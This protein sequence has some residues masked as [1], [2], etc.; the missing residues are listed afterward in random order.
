MLDL[1]LPT[2]KNPALYFT[3]FFN[4]PRNKK[5]IKKFIKDYPGKVYLAE[6]YPEGQKKEKV[7]EFLGL[8]FNNPKAKIIKMFYHS[9]HNFNEKFFKEKLRL[10]KKDFG[11]RF[12]PA[13][14]TIAV[15]IQG[16]EPIL[17]AEQLGND[18][19]LAKEAKVEEVIIFRLGGLDKKYVNVLK[20]V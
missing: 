15:G 20:K 19:R 9:M 1:E 16:N 17:S 18:L 11:K 4:F 7:L 13:F 10:G 2:T 3:Q 5:I 6:Y 12:I 14:G 8:H